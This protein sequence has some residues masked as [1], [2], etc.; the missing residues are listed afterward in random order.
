MCVL[1]F[2]SPGWLPLHSGKHNQRA[3][4]KHT[5]GD[6][7]EQCLSTGSQV[8][9]RTAGVVKLQPAFAGKCPCV[10]L[11]WLLQGLGVLV[12]FCANSCQVIPQKSPCGLFVGVDTSDSI[13]FF[14]L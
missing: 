7:R 9:Q 14:T 11:W 6:L 13:L 4:R 2:I 12:L 3:C 8:P 1:S 5:G 10:R